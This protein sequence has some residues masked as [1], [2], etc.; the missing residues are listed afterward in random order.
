M[1]V[2]GGIRKTSNVVTVGNT[3]TLVYQVTSGRSAKVRKLWAYNS[4]ASA[5]TVQ[6]CDSDGNAKSP[7]ISVGATSHVVLGELDL[8]SIEFTSDIYMIADAGDVISVLI[9]VEE[10]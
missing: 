3:A 4:D 5:H 6:F 1:S 7:N 10:V 8:P 2:I 9:E